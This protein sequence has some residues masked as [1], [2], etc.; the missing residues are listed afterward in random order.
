MKVHI[1]HAHSEG[2]SFVNAMKTVIADQFAADG[3]EVS[4]S[5]LYAKG[6]NPVASPADFGDRRDPDRL[7][8]TL[9]Q[10]HNYQGG[11]LAADIVAE[12]E[13]VLAADML[14]FTFPIYW[15]GAPA[16]LKGWFDRVLLSGVCYGGKRV[17]GRGGLAGKRSF[18]A[19]SLGG[20]HD[21][22]GERGLHGELVQGM[23]RHLFQGTLGYIG[24]TVL[25]P[26]IGFN[27][28]YIS[29]EART[30]LLEDLRRTVADI[31]SRPMLPV[32]D[33]NRFDDRFAPLPENAA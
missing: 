8:Y 3:H 1:V 13:P 2:D 14:V 30:A 24:T 18:A 11:T 15:F 16:I 19:M 27:V 7:V 20:R 29:L 6:F 31:D 9:E 28:P 4:L 17:Y 32:P 26:F 22:F 5:D 23:M 21:M 10:R 12:L 33:L 25:D